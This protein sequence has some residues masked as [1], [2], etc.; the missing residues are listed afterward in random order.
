MSIA[1]GL[2]GAAM[3]AGQWGAKQAQ[4][5]IDNSSWK[6]KQDYLDSKQ[7]ARDALARTYTVEDRDLNNSRQDKRFEV[8][9][10]QAD[11]AFGEQVRGNKASEGIALKNANTSAAHLG[12]AQQG[13]DLQNKQFKSSEQDKE[14]ARQAVHIQEAYGT[15]SQLGLLDSE[16]KVDTNKAAAMAKRMPARANEILAVLNLAQK[17]MPPPKALTQSQL[18]YLALNGTP[19][20]KK[21]ATEVLTKQPPLP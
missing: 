12:I 14:T 2:I 18:N 10:G 5:N 1:E 7:Q 11:R 19:E 20:Q 4:D 15:A 17:Y 21:A 9:D 13:M 3:G 6:T 8:A 16:G